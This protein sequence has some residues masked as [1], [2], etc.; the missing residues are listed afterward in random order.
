MRFF[1]RCFR[2]LRWSQAGA[3]FGD[4]DVPI[5]LLDAHRGNTKI[6]M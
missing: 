2:T 5:S 6:Q 3:P 1:Q 4:V